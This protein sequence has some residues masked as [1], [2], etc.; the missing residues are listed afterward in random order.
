MC[1]RCRLAHPRS[2]T[3]FSVSCYQL[4]VH[5]IRQCRQEYEISLAGLFRR[6]AH[7][8]RAS[9]LQPRLDRRIAQ[10]NLAIVFQLML[11]HIYPGGSPGGSTRECGM[12]GVLK[13]R[14]RALGRCPS[15]AGFLGGPFLARRISLVSTRWGV[16][17]A[18][19]VG[20]WTKVGDKKAC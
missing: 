3:S 16:G 15:R 2:P 19:W 20:Y 4:A 18:G 11:S 5:G 1:S 6:N 10:L 13:V 9:A 8:H 17:G 12:L 14:A 7:V